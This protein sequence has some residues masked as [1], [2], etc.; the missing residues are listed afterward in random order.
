[1]K[2]YIFKVTDTS[3]VNAK[4]FLRYIRDLNFIKPV[5]TETYAA[6]EGEPMLLTTFRKR[7]RESEA[8]AAKGNFLT[9]DEVKKEIRNLKNGKK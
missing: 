6:G 2:Q 4:A 5:K 8:D 3:S 1:M 7:I 9:T